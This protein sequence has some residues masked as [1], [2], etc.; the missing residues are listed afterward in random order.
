MAKAEKKPA[1]KKERASKYDEKL[2]FDGTFEELIALT[3]KGADDVVKK[4]DNK[5]KDKQNG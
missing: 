3:V 2:K 1:P 5:Q 4:R